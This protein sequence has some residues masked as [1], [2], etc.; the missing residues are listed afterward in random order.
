MYGSI[1]NGFKSG[2]F[3]GANPIPPPV[4]SLPG[5]GVSPPTRSAPTPR[6][7]QHAAQRKALFYYDYQDKQEQDAV[8]LVGNISGL[9][10][11]DES[12]IYGAGLADLAAH[13][14]FNPGCEWRLARV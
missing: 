3:N 7:W 12:E 13:R 5:R 8:T 6:W 4:D 11:V 14:G 2:G 10:N 9:T 1:S